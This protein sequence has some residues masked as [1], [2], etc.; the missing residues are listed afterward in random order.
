MSSP[1]P[2]RQVDC[3]ED[4]T[5]Y[6]LPRVPPRHLGRVNWCTGWLGP[7][8]D[9]F[10]TIG[11][12]RTAAIATLCRID[13]GL[14]PESMVNAQVVLLRYID[15]LEELC[16]CQLL[17]KRAHVLVFCWQFLAEARGPPGYSKTYA[18]TVDMPSA[19]VSFELLCVF[20]CVVVLSYHRAL[21]IHEFHQ[22]DKLRVKA[23]YNDCIQLVARMQDVYA[24]VLSQAHLSAM[25]KEG[26]PMQLQ[27]AW[28]RTFR[29]YLAYKLLSYA[30]PDRT[31]EQQSAAHYHMICAREWLS[32][33]HLAPHQIYVAQ[34]AYD[35]ADVLFACQMVRWLVSEARIA[36]TGEPEIG[37]ALVTA[38]RVA[39]AGLTPENAASMAEIVEQCDETHRVFELSL[40]P[41]ASKERVETWL[42]VERGLEPRF[43]KIAWPEKPETI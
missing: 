37:M 39:I 34:R 31:F 12:Q 41:P 20:L 9:R 11:A 19:Y 14:S 18:Q 5:L 22:R 16:K 30:A 28:L 3:P 43:C 32:C 35:V 27:P 42:V 17:P 10:L 38:A 21:V 24:R 36:A 23:A 1:A 4:L 40:T 13:E 26:L 2:L 29:S 6:D 33:P 15:S 8:E 7:V 25:L